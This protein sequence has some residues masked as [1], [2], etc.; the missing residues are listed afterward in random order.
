[1]TES[2]KTAWNRGTAAGR[3]VGALCILAALLAAPARVE[4]QD[5]FYDWGESAEV[6]NCDGRR[7]IFWVDVDNSVRHAYLV[8]GTIAT[9]AE[10]DLGGE[11]KFDWIVVFRNFDC[12]IEVFGVG[13]DNAMWTI[14]QTR[15]AA[16]PWSAWHSIG[17]ILTGRPE[18]Y[19]DQYRNLLGVC[20]LGADTP[21]RRWCNNHTQPYGSPWTGWWRW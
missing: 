15:P 12:K 13:G 14:W 5:P 8:P 6:A 3:A 1:M 11:I 10:E 21:P 16:G 20:A 7:E 2:R 19:W 9:W 17:G 18:M 4:A